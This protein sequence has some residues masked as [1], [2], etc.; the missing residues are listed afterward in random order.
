VDAARALADLTEISAQIEAA[1]LLDDSGVVLA[2]TTDEHRAAAL[3][4]AAHA[5][6]AAADAAA[7]GPVVQLE[8][9]LREGAV[10]AVRHGARTL[11]AATRARPT[12][13][14]VLYDLRSCLRSL[15][16]APKPKKRRPR[17]KQAA[18]APAAAPAP[19]EGTD[20]PA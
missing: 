17:R 6:L 4:E 3:A 20:A 13:G 18:A 1:I 7:G 8:A 11:V 2:S 19:V 16:E 12:S 9:D 5:V 15:D 10:F 14:L